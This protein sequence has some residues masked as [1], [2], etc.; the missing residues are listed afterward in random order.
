MKQANLGYLMFYLIYPD[1]GM[2]NYVILIT[3]GLFIWFQ[4]A[5]V[6]HG[7]MVRILPP[8]NCMI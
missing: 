5:K 6:L 8:T 2:K 4:A 3:L 7:D 1:P